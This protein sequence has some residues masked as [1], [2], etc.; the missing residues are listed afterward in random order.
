ML[1]LYIAEIPKV[2]QGKPFETIILIY[3]MSEQHPSYSVEITY[4]EHPEGGFLH[5]GV[6]VTAPGSESVLLAAKP[7]MTKP[8]LKSYDYDLETMIKKAEQNA[9]KKKISFPEKAKRALLKLGDVVKD[10]EWA[11]GETFKFEYRPQTSS[12]TEA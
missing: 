2:G 7:L 8:S 10:W 12:R 6:Y 5:F 1:E 4:K 3:R 9:D 11:V